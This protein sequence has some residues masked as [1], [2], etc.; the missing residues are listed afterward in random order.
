M[1][2]E[3]IFYLFKINLILEHIQNLTFLVQNSEILHCVIKVQTLVEISLKYFLI[4]ISVQFL[5]QKPQWTYNKE[6]K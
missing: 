3:T 4:K 6:L 2:F 1:Y 5:G